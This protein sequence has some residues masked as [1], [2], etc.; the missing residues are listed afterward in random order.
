MAAPLKH[1]N[2]ITRN[3]T[4]NVFVVWIWLYV[5][6]KKRHTRT[7]WIM[8]TWVQTNFFCHFYVG[9]M[10]LSRNRGMNTHNFF[11]NTCSTSKVSFLWSGSCRTMTERNDIQGSIESC[12][13]GGKRTFFAIFVGEKFSHYMDVILTTVASQITSLAVVYSFVHS[14]ADERKIKAPRHWPLCGGSQR[15]SNVENVSIW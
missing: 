10:F 15:A 6:G 1:P 3:Y 4:D 2:N 9:K 5:E 7:Y 13:L 11:V 12:L 14:G 8:S